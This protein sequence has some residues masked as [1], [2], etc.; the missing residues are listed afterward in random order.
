MF[1]EPDG[2]KIQKNV[3]SQRFLSCWATETKKG[4]APAQPFP[5]MKKYV[6]VV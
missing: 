1:S 4:R 2:A 3:H 6:K 5:M